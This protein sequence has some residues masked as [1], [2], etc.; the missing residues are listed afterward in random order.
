[1]RK[2]IKPPKLISGDTV[3]IVSP[4]SAFFPINES[5]F[6]RSIAY[7]EKTGLHIQIAPHTRDQWKHLNPP[8]QH[9]AAEI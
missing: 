6:Q 5:A 9:R 1:M 2:L 7:L 8:A 4:A 3:G